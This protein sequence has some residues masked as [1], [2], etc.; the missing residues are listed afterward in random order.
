MTAHALAPLLG[1]LARHPAKVEVLIAELVYRGLLSPEE[2]EFHPV[3]T[4]ARNYSHDIAGVRL[5]EDARGERLTLYVHREGLY[6]QLPYFLFHQPEPYSPGRRLQERLELNEVARQQEQTARRFFLPLEQEFFHLAVGTELTERR[7]SAGFNNPLRRRLLLDIWP[8][9]TRVPARTLPVLSYILPLS[10]HIA[11][12]LELM[13]ACYRAVLLVPVELRYATPRGPDTLVETE[14]P[15]EQRLGL[16]FD[17]GGLPVAELPE[18]E[19]HL[20]PLERLQANDFL[21]GAGGDEALNLLNECL[22]P[23]ELDVRAVLHFTE[24]AEELRLGRGQEDDSRLAL[25]SRLS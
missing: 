23:Y 19:I 4:F 20:G 15:G 22:V 13:T 24:P 5:T 21:P 12:D 11:G 17:L 7:L 9:C 18:L 6:D 8:H 25:T 1:A 2:V 3:S 14:L 10:Y 16:D